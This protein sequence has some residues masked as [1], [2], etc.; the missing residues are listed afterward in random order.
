MDFSFEWN[1]DKNRENQEKHGVSFQEAQFA[2]TDSHLLILRDERHSTP[3]EE[4]FYG[5]GRIE[6]GIV[7]VRFTVRNQVIRI[8]GAG[9]WRK[10]RRRYLERASN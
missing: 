3:E 10:Y 7:T 5:V 1:E 9:F 2:F 6:G 8:F 4:R